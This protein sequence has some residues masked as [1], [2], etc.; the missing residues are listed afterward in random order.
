MDRIADA[1]TDRA[2]RALDRP[3]SRRGLLGKMVRGSVALGIAAV[4]FRGLAHTAKA[5][6]CVNVSCNNCP[7]GLCTSN[8]CPPFY[9]PT[10]ISTCCESP[11]EKGCWLC[12]PTSGGSNCG[13][14]VLTGATC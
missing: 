3:L 13:C 12:V 11:I 5:A 2:I 1:L 4:G 6:C 7:T 14:E 9:T 10:L 8:C